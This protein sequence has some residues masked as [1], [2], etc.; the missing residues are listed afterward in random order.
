MNNRLMSVC[1]WFMDILQNVNQV[2][3]PTVETCKQMGCF[4]ARQSELQKQIFPATC[5]VK[6]GIGILLRKRPIEV[7][8]ICKCKFVFRT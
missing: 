4:N 7:I 5:D 6:R 1:A 8:S 2:V 3:V